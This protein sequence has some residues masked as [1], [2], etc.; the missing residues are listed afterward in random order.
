M[1]YHD[2]CIREKSK[3]MT[4]AKWYRRDVF[5]KDCAS[6]DTQSQKGLPFLFPKNKLQTRSTHNMT[7]S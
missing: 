7:N 6:F 3:D 4:K 5:I 2:K 1:F